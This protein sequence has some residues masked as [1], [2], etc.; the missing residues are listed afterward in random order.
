MK[1]ELKDIN[2]LILD[3]DPLFN[4]ILKKTAKKSGLTVTTSLS[5]KKAH[6]LLK[7][8]NNFNAVLLDYDL[9]DMTGVEAAEKI[10]AM[11]PDIPIFLISATFR[12]QFDMIQKAPNYKGFITKWQGYN[13]ILEEIATKSK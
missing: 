8:K 4:E 7:G 2:Y 6:R 10:G 12:P 1:K 3:D 5:Y 9:E 11:C 13:N